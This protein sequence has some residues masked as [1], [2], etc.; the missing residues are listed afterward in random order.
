MKPSNAPLK[1]GGAFVVRVD[2]AFDC[3]D[4]AAHSLETI[5]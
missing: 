5:Q 2:R 1:D 4:L 3:L